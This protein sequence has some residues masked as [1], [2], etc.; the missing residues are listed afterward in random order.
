MHIT[1]PNCTS[2]FKL[3]AELLGR[4]GRALKCASCGHSWYQT[5][6]VESMDLASIM[7]EEYAAQAQAAAGLPRMRSAV[8]AA[9]ASRSAAVPSGMAR[10]APAA[11]PPA[12]P[13]LP[14]GAVSMMGRGKPAMA[15][16]AQ[17]APGAQAAP[18]VRAPDPVAAALSGQSMRGRTGAGTVGQSAV[19]LMHSQGGAGAAQGAVG[20][21]AQPMQGG[22]VGGPVAAALSGQS[23]RGQAG[24]SGPGQAATS[25]M[26][27]NP[28]GA[29]RFADVGRHRVVGSGR[30]VAG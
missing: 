4:K 15:A 5:A 7:G 14:G 23:M 22:T 13:P 8:S 29:G 28:A 6:Q 3:P 18:G 11:P 25:W 9:A 1:C 12:E 2:G 10:M 27:N 16:G 21:P 20:A 30:E 17:S 26:Q 24:A 19:S